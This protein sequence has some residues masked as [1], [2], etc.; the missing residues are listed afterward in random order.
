MAIASSTL[1]IGIGVAGALVIL[2][3][4]G[5]VIRHRQRAKRQAYLNPTG[6]RS[7][8]VNFADLDLISQPPKGK[9]NQ[10][11]HQL[12]GSTEVGDCGTSE[13]ETSRPTDVGPNPKNQKGL[14]MTDGKTPS[15]PPVSPTGPKGLLMADG[16]T[17]P[18]PPASP[19]GHPSFVKM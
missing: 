11:N 19:C 7:S 12:S 5:A 1:S 9:R 14:E 2:A 17:P 18:K 13:C 3:L 4:I 10:P 8:V 6:R 15:K 16:K